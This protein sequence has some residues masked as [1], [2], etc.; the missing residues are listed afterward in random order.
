MKKIQAIIVALTLVTV[1]CGQRTENG[2]PPATPY[3]NSASNPLSSSP[4]IL[5]IVADDL[6][7]TDLGSYGSEISTPNLDRI[8]QE[9]TKFSQ[10]HVAAACSP[11][12]AM[13]LTGVDNHIVGL[14]AFN[15][16]TIG[17]NQRG[18]AGYEAHL[19][20]RAASMA[21]IFIENGYHTYITGKWHLGYEANSTPVVHGFQRSF[22]QLDGGA[23][24]FNELPAI[25]FRRQASF[26]EDG[27]PVNLPD[28][29]YSS[30]FYVHQMINYINEDRS[31]GK[32][33]LAYL[34]FTAPHWPLQ[35]KAETIRKYQDKYLDGFER[36]AQQR[37]KKLVEL[38]ILENSVTPVPYNQD[39]FRRWSTL[40][41]QEK[42]YE[43]KRMAI[44]AAMIDDL[45]SAT[46]VLIQYLKDIGEFDNTLI[47]FL[48]DNGAEGHQAQE[49]EPLIELATVLGIPCCDNSHENIGNADSFIGLGPEW[50]QASVGPHRIYKGYPTQGG[51]IAPAFIRPPTQEGPEWY[52]GFTSVKDILPTMLEFAGIDNHN[53]TFK[54]RSVFPIEGK[55]IM[56][57]LQGK[58]DTVHAN[59]IN[60]GWQLFTKHAV[61]VGDWKLL[62]LPRP[63]GNNE[64]ELYYLPS[65]PAE[66]KNLAKQEPER[67]KTLIQ[68]WE[69]YQQQS[70]VII[71]EL[72]WYIRY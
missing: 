12:R 19:N 30:D 38:D 14:G 63:Y 21:E 59:N 66:T 29:F 61:R 5:L 50:A 39:I 65:D 69:K 8:A 47:V 37:Q 71:P 13:L 7:Y 60:M 17:K 11:T 45:D 55:S 9:G 57:L 26:R 22:V 64:W 25:P 27:V 34:A 36:L 6:G 46:G 41:H 56:P 68:H 10:F 43:A 72:P 23:G 44:Y 54:G 1:G 51:I 67:L 4:N 15:P 3:P 52:K 31:T 33:F 62:R 28:G 53:N 42:A 2:Q 32:P 16:E 20:F 48:S 49:T 58:A 40:S 35:A 70:N 18:I 24:H